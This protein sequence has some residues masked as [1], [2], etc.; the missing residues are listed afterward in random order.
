[1]VRPNRARRGWTNA[2]VACRP[3]ACGA[4]LE[5]R[6]DARGADHGDETRPRC[7]ASGFGDRITRHGGID[8][9]PRLSDVLAQH[10]TQAPDVEMRGW[11][12]GAGQRLRRPGGIGPQA[13][14]ADP[15]RAAIHA[16]WSGGIPFERGTAGRP[17]ARP[18]ACTRVSRYGPASVCSRCSTSASR[19]EGCQRCSSGGT[20]RTS[21]R[22]SGTA[23]A[24]T[25]QVMTAEE[26]RCNS[27]RTGGYLPHVG[28]SSAARAAGIAR[29]GTGEGH[30]HRAMAGRRTG[31]A[32]GR[33]RW[34]GPCPMTSIPGWSCCMHVAALLDSVL[35]DRSRKV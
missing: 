21:S 24:I 30:R 20:T 35:I 22:T 33:R 2:A 29:R 12:V 26:S 7:P 28:V 9:A 16:A 15:E 11:I 17:G 1:M 14:G 4:L 25:S 32:G 13:G 8:G 10:A 34:R 27:G 19:S 23:S 6:Q 18:P 5:A 31:S 3:W